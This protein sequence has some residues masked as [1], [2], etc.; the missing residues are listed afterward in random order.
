M[1]LAS[2]QLNFVIEWIDRDSVLEI[3]ECSRE[4]HTICA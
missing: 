2:T 3:G 1:T 4:L